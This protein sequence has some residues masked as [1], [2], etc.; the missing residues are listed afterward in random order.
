MRD[1]VRGGA[2]ATVIDCKYWEKLERVAGI[3]PA[4]SAWEAD[5][6]PLHH[7][8]NLQDISVSCSHIGL[9]QIGE[10][11]TLGHKLCSL[12]PPVNL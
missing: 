2:V 9:N 1:V 11:G 10:F 3:E 7:T 4:R 6:L 12:Y 5:R 8:R